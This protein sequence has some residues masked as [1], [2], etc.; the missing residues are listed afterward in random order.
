MQHDVK[1]GVMP[2]SFFPK[3]EGKL[4]KIKQQLV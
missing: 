2:S 1:P 4:A 3:Y